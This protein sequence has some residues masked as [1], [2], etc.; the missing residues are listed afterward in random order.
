MWLLNLLRLHLLM[1]LAWESLRYVGQKM[2]TVQFEAI[3][4]PIRLGQR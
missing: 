1:L 3:L 2:E 4:L